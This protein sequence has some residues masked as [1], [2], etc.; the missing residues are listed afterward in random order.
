[1][2]SEQ[3]QELLEAFSEIRTIGQT[4]A[5]NLNLWNENNI[6]EDSNVDAITQDMSGDTVIV[7]YTE[8]GFTE[9]EIFQIITS[10]GFSIPEESDDTIEIEE[11]SGKTIDERESGFLTK[12]IEVSHKYSGF[13]KNVEL[14]TGGEKEKD[15]VRI[16]LAADS[17][18]RKMPH[19]SKTKSTFMHF[20]QDIREVEKEFSMREENMCYCKNNQEFVILT[21]QANP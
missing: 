13:V 18:L 5:T 10:V 19:T 1:M 21:K 3:Q 12:C 8:N 11:C 17:D 9:E 14:H 6:D 2:L 4:L 15:S 7:L 20:L 16:V